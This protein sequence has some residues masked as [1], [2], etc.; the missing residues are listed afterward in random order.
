MVTGGC[1][2]CP[3]A[4]AGGRVLYGDIFLSEVLDHQHILLLGLGIKG[5]K[6]GAAAPMPKARQSF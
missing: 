4:I 2:G 3:P 1:R 5:E 6:I